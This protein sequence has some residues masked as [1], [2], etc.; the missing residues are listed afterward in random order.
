[1]PLKADRSLR[2]PRG[3]P[4]D[5]LAEGDDLAGTDGLG[6]GEGTDDDNDI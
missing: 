4:G 1:M 2:M 6:E 3:D 5:D